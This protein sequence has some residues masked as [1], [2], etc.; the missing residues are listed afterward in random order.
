MQKS[1]R[2]RMATYQLNK[3]TRL[4][5]VASGSVLLLLALSQLAPFIAST[6]LAQP[7]LLEAS[8]V[9]ISLFISILVGFGIHRWLSSE[10]RL[11]DIGIGHVAGSSETFV[12]WSDLTHFGTQK[13]RLGYQVGIYAHPTAEED[14]DE[15]FIPLNDYVDLPT[16]S[17]QQQPTVDLAAL[18]ET[19]FGQQVYNHAPHLFEEDEQTILPYKTKNDLGYMHDTEIQNDTLWQDDDKMTTTTKRKD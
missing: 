18:R 16:V 3:T 1:K 10:I 15:L 13:T 11:Y 5:F 17:T 19:A 6:L 8:A 9:F 14:T 7:L 2:K 4:L 12:A